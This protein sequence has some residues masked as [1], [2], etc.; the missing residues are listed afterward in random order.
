LLAYKNRVPLPG[1]PEKIIPGVITSYISV[2]SG[3]GYNLLRPERF[4]PATGEA[5]KDIPQLLVDGNIP[6]TLQIRG[7]KDIPRQSAQISPSGAFDTP[8]GDMGGEIHTC[9]FFSGFS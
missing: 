1:G 8:K 3:Y 6:Q 5:E 7:E 9:I 2:S 4:I